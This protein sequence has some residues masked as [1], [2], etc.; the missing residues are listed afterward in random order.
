MGCGSPDVRSRDISIP[1]TA[2]TMRPLVSRLSSSRPWSME[3]KAGAMA[4]VDMMLRR[5]GVG[6][7]FDQERIIC[8]L[9]F[10]IASD[11]PQYNDDILDG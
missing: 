2:S 11:P 1:H 4:M 9:V 5:M 10:I 3:A 7:T 6:H 8:P